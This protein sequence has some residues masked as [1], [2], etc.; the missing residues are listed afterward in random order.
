MVKHKAHTVIWPYCNLNLNP[1]QC[2]YHSLYLLFPQKLANYKIVNYCDGC[3][4]WV[5]A[6][7]QLK[8][9]NITPCVNII[10]LKHVEAEVN[11]DQDFDG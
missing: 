2:E 5:D 11:G 6:S 4:C 3:A 7:P 8:Q 1:A 9:T 10:D